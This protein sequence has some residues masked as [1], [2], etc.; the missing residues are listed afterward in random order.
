MPYGISL[1]EQTNQK[2]LINSKKAFDILL[3]VKKK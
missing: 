2:T 1:E 3:K